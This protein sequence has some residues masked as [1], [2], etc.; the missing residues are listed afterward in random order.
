MRCGRRFLGLA[1]AALAWAS[2][3]M[4]DRYWALDVGA[5]VDNVTQ[6]LSA[7]AG[8]ASQVSSISGFFRA[9]RGFN[10]GGPFTFE[11]GIGTRI[12]WRSSADGT[13]LTFTFQLDLDLRYDL[14]SF[15]SLRAG[16]G[17]EVLTTAASAKTVSLSNGTSTSQFYVPGGVS[18]IFLATISAGLE[19]KLFRGIS[20]NLDIWLPD[21][22]SS[23][24]RR[25][26]GAASLG[27]RL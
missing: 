24:R 1:L 21:I 3:A 26:E 2:P 15:L 19:L 14:F 18:G 4:A 22:G 13:A 23:S 27:L 5:Y 8:Y 20:L 12:P 17:L 7:P 10:L 6:R 25:L 11:P 16:P 9:R